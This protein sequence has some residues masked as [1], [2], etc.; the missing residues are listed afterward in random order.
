MRSR[1]DTKP[2]LTYGGLPNSMDEAR[3]VTTEVN[4]GPFRSVGVAGIPSFPTLT[5]GGQS[6]SIMPPPS[7]SRGL[8]YT[9]PPKLKYNQEKISSPFCD[10]FSS[11]DA[12]PE[13]KAKSSHLSST[14]WDV[15]DYTLK[16]KP[17][18]YPLEQT[19]TFVPHTKP[20]VVASRIA[21][22]LLERN[23]SVT[24]NDIKAKAKCVSKDNVEFN[25]RLFK[26]KNQFSHGVI[27]EVQRRSGFSVFY[28][29]D[30]VS[31]LDVASGKTPLEPLE[32]PFFNHEAEQCARTQLIY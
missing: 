9:G 29:R 5:R 32:E 19:A 1:Y 14:R 23:I 16:P 22:F 8:Q 2:T 12:Y 24:F 6:S 28:H 30:T 15:D 7:L 10:S 17:D 27:V 31:I 18:F 3:S 26:G 11:F 25:I 21:N 20:S 4:E 13:P